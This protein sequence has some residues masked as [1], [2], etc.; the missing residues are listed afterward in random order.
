MGQSI[1][2]RLDTENELAVQEARAQVVQ[3]HRIDAVPEGKAHAGADKE[4]VEA[5]GVEIAD[6][7]APGPVVLHTQGVGD[8]SESAFPQVLVESIAEDVVGAALQ[9]FVGPGHHGLEL[10][11][12]GQDFA[13]HV[14]VHV[15]QHQVHTTV[16]VEVEE[17]DSHG[18][19]RRAW[20]M[21]RAAIDK[22][23]TTLGLL[24]DPIVV[25][26]LHVEHIELRVAVAIE[27]DERGIAAP[28]A[29]SQ[30]H[31][32]GNL[33]EPLA[34]D[35]AIEE[36]VLGALGIEMTAEGVLQSDVIAARSLL[37]D[38]VDADTGDEQVQKA[39]VVVV[40]E[41]RA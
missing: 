2:P 16:V 10:L 37:V 28:A 40:E 34:V 17:L 5:I 13:A 4:I 33:L 7:Q 14:R 1:P 6:A 39:I 12:L 21:L 22:A 3:Q 19:P 25:V 36:A 32:F 30:A 23:T 41:D 11:F 27:I 24:A 29:V 35:V 26:T 9:V 8:L 18:A 15:A 20:K 38:G 31:L